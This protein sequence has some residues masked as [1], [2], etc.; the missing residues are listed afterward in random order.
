MHMQMHICSYMCTHS[1]GLRLRQAALSTP[2][3]QAG[4]SV[5]LCPLPLHRLIP[6]PILTAQGWPL[7]STLC[8]CQPQETHLGQPP[9][10]AGQ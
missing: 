6:N 7:L 5:P 8:G 3:P 10:G 1:S 4:S 2:H 9:P